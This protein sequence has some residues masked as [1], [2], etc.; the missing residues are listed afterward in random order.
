MC[1]KY[2][3]TLT[4]NLDDLLYIVGGICKSIPPM[5]L[6][7]KLVFSIVSAFDRLFTCVSCAWFECCSL[8]QMLD[9]PNIRKP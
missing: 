6:T 3:K 7:P 8:Q 4:S 5:S 1:T 9:V 2:K